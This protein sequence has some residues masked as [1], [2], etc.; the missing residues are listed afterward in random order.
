[1]K[2]NGDGGGGENASEYNQS[3]QWMNFAFLHLLQLYCL[4]TFL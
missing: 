1:M 3:L 4:L 2:A